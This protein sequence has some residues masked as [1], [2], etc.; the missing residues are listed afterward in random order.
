MLLKSLFSISFISC[1]VGSLPFIERN[2][3]KKTSNSDISSW[4]AYVAIRSNNT[5]DDSSDSLEDI[6]FPFFASSLYI[7]IKDKR[8]DVCLKKKPAFFRG[9]A[10]YG[11]GTLLVFSTDTSPRGAIEVGLARSSPAR[12][13]MGALP[14]GGR[15][16]RRLICETK[17]S[18][19]AI[20]SIPP[21]IFLSSAR[22]IGSISTC[23]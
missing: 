22:T 18:A 7:G 17:R 9:R 23:K 14:G 3:L 5:S 4:R 2:A 1:L 10:G 12:S 11:A 6:C 13:G 16:A 8:E 15:T 20:C 21:S 19:P